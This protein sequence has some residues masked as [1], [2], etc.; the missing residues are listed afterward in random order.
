MLHGADPGSKVILGGLF[1]RPL[2]IPPNVQSGDFLTRLYRAQP[3]KRFFDGVALH[4]YVADAGAMRAQIENLRRVMRVH[5]DAA[6]PLYVTELG[7]GSDSGESRWERGMLGQARRAG[8]GL[9]AARRQPPALADR[10]RRLVLLDRPAGACQF[11]D[12]AGLLTQ[13]GEAKPAW[14]ASTPGPTAIPTPS[15]AC[16]LPALG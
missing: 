6:T 3:V 14:Y 15:R 9:L 11:C 8:R 2:Q 16:V 1:G 12:S 7:W 5:H 4:P 13:T 10:R